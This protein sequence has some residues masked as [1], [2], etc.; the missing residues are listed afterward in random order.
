MCVNHSLILALTNILLNF[1]LVAGDILDLSLTERTD[2]SLL[3]LVLRMK[4]SN[5]IEV[6]HLSIV[7]DTKH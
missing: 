2:K 3:E 7:A 6:S 4:S 1:F 5:R